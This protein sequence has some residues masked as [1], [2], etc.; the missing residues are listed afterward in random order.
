L[1]R[2]AAI[3]GLV[4]LL[5][6]ATLSSASAVDVGRQL[7]HKVWT[8]E[9][10]L[11]RRSM[12]RAAWR[13]IQSGRPGRCRTL[14]LSGLQAVG[15]RAGGC[16]AAVRSQR[17]NR[18][19]DAAPGLGRECAAPASCLVMVRRVR[20]RTRSFT[21]CSTRMT[22]A[23]TSTCSRS[24]HR[25]SRRPPAGCSA[26]R[27]T[28]RCTSATRLSCSRTTTGSRASR[29]PKVVGKKILVNDYPMTIVGVSQAGFAEIDPARSLRIR[30]PILMKP[31]MLP[32][33]T[34]L[35]IDDRARTSRTC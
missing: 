28:I 24:R 25:R 30:V 3:L 27:K 9:E 22:S 4:A 33:W 19:H 12:A 5:C 26:R 1:C 6:S 18:G 23:M 29:D 14:Q 32:D 31:V 35:K 16:L 20:G 8:A 11:G 2:L 13:A 15:R 21:S 34:W 10:G 17:N 7:F